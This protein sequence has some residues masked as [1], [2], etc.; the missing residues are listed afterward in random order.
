MK[1]TEFLEELVDILELE[2]DGVDLDTAISLDSLAILSVIA[3][4]DENFSKK[5][6]A[7]ELK[8]V[9]SI[10]DILKLAGENN[11]ES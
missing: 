7:E 8:A 4:L 5:A 10:N 11:I 2:E 1:K 3:F 9:T 6:S